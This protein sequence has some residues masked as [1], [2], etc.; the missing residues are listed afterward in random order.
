MKLIGFVKIGKWK[1]EQLNW[2][3]LTWQ[4][5]FTGDKWP[6]QEGFIDWVM[7][8]VAYEDGMVL[9]VMLNGGSGESVEYLTEEQIERLEVREDRFFLS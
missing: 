3:K 1:P 8:A 9:K 5:M 4:M 6:P 2:Q 7:S